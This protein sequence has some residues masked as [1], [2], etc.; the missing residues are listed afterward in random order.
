MVVPRSSSMQ[1]LKRDPLVGNW[2]IVRDARGQPRQAGR[3]NSKTGTGDYLVRMTFDAGGP[4]HG[5]T[6]APARL[7]H[8]GWLL[9]SNEASWRAA[10]AAMVK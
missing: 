6:V 2:F 8:D 9:F 10:F 3:I 4:S 5:E 1:D 7:T